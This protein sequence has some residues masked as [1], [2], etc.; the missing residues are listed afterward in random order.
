MLVGADTGGSVTPEYE[1]PFHFTGTLKRVIVDV[2]GKQV[3]DYEAAMKVVL[4]KQ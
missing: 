3:E 2:S 1:A 4:A